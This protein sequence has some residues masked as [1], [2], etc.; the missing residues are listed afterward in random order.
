MMS[1]VA[2]LCFATIVDFSN[3][4]ILAS[5][6]ALSGDAGNAG[7]Y[8]PVLA[9]NGR[10][11][12]FES[13]ATNLDPSDVTTDHDVFVLDRQGTGVQLAKLGDGN[14]DVIGDCYLDGVSSNGRYVCFSSSASGVVPG[15]IPNGIQ[16]YVHDRKTGK[17]ILA[18][19]TTMG[20]PLLGS[21][22]NASLSPNGRYCVFTTSAS[23]VVPGVSTGILQAYVRD[24]KAGK[25][26]LA[27]VGFN[28]QPANGDCFAPKVSNDGRYVFFTSNA[29]TLVPVDANQ[30]HDVFVRDR[31]LHT[32][33]R[34][35]LGANGELAKGAGEYRITPNGKTIFFTTDSD[36]LGDGS[37]VYRGIYVRNMATGEVDAAARTQQGSL[38]GGIESGDFAISKSGRYLAFTTYYTSIVTPDP[39]G[40]KRDVFVADRKLGT[41]KIASVGMGGTGV[42]A[43]CS[44][45]EISGN[46]HVVAYDSMATNLNPVPSLGKTQVFYTEP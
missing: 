18:S 35:A 38:V 42:N 20:G 33:L 16:E 17:T 4:S 14:T 46:G 40:S 19:M 8:R 11:V 34:A 44:H 3:P 32:T 12:F 22:Y 29:T 6:N 25:T 10:L 26:E 24:L 30:T 5:R 43:D 15:V 28:S 41:V 7:A 45:A 21:I 39:S 27:S 1:L 37:S 23:D 2:T 36:A 31:K 9:K 13:G